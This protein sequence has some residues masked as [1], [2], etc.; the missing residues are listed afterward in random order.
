MKT[1]CVAVRRSD[2]NSS[3]VPVLPRERCSLRTTLLP[4]PWLNALQVRCGR[5]C[6]DQ[7]DPGPQCRSCRVSEGLLPHPILGCTS[8]NGVVPLLQEPLLKLPA[9]LSAPIV[10]CFS[11]PAWRVG[12]LKA[13]FSLPVCQ[14]SLPTVTN[15]LHVIIYCSSNICVNCDL[16]W[17]Q[18]RVFPSRSRRKI[19]SIP[20]LRAELSRS[21]A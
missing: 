9:L 3:A 11:G 18:A 12:I 1:R 14:H 15:P 19:P 8:R 2:D 20:G 10:F 17:Q 16:Y 6:G 5:R 4:S 7:V 13:T 21:R